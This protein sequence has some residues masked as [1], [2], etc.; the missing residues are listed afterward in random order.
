[1]GNIRIRPELSSPPVSESRGGKLSV[2]NGGRGGGWTEI[3]LSNIGLSVE[4]PLA[5]PESANDIK[6]HR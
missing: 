3:P 4:Q 2:T 6:F 1:M 5:S